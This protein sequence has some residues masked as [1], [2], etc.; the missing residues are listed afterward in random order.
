MLYFFF[1]I[2][3]SLTRSS[4]LPHPLRPPPSPSLSLL[5]QKMAGLP[6]VLVVV[7]LA[8][9]AALADP[10]PG[11][12]APCYDKTAYIT[13]VQP[14]VQEVRRCDSFCDFKLE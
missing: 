8:A 5:T 13:K 4:F 10:E 2:I 3:E 12:P 14:I 6:R 9:A 7:V 1:Y 11:Y